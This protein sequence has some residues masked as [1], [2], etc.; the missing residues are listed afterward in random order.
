MNREKRM[1]DKQLSPPSRGC[2]LFILVILSSLTV[3][4]VVRVF[5]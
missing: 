3:Y 4:E 2:F 5:V 1:R